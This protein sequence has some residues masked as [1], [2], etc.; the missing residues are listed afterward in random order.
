MIAHRRHRRYGTIKYQQRLLAA[1]G[2][3]ADIR[4][5]DTTWC[6]AGYVTGGGVAGSSQRDFFLLVLVVDASRLSLLCIYSLYLSF[7]SG[8]PRT[9]RL[10]AL[11]GGTDRDKECRSGYRISSSLTSS[12]ARELWHAMAWRSQSLLM[13]L[14]YIDGRTATVT[15]RHIRRGLKACGLTCGIV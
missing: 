5:I 2:A 3:S 8:F 12:S 1:S 14:H 11:Y 15:Q 7:S 13:G 9:Q 10:S 4:Y 6:I